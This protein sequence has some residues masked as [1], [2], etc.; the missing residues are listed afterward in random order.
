[1]SAQH[2]SFF[3]WALRR[4]SRNRGWAPCT[5]SSWFPECRL[6]LKDQGLVHYRILQFKGMNSRNSPNLNVAK[7]IPYSFKI[8][9]ARTPSQIQEDIPNDSAQGNF[10]NPTYRSNSRGPP[11]AHPEC[12]CFRHFSFCNEPSAPV[13][14]AGWDIPMF[15]FQLGVPFFKG[16]ITTDQPS[17]AS[18]SAYSAYSARSQRSTRGTLAPS[19][20]PG[21]DT[22]SPPHGP[23]RCSPLLPGSPRQVTGDEGDEVVFHLMGRSQSHNICP[24]LYWM[25]LPWRTFLTPW[26]I[27]N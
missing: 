20:G 12:M 10:L 13:N 3:H 14:I 23:Q 11:L 2:T 26:P 17:A 21:R 6:G 4:A 15:I 1:M 27:F 16:Q 5:R 7:K 9:V 25:L 8:L 22:W 24:S 18:H 19:P